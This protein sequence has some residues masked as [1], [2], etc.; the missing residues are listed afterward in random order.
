MLG[1]QRARYVPDRQVPGGVSRVL[2]DMPTRPFTCGFAG[3]R[4]PCTHSQADS[5]VLRTSTGMNHCHVIGRIG[6]PLA[7]TGIYYASPQLL[8]AVKSSH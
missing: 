4:H 8:A 6:R 1:M 5:P 2:T 7:V 3:E